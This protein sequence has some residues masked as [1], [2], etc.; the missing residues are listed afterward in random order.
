MLQSDERPRLVI[1]QP[2]PPNMIAKSV[3]FLV[4]YPLSRS[5][6]PGIR[7][8]SSH[9][10]LSSQVPS[11]WL[12]LSSNELTVHSKAVEGIK[13][14][15]W[16]AMLEGLISKPLLV[17]TE[18]IRLGKLNGKAYMDWSTFLASATARLRVTPR[19]PLGESQD[20]AM[21]R[22]LSALHVLRCLLGPCIESLIIWDRYTWAMEAIRKADS[23]M[24]VGL[25]NLFDQMKGSGRN[26]AI[27]LKAR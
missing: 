25:V 9:L 19:R 15:A 21:E 2:P 24:E 4:D 14:V 16:R 6:A 3:Y 11:T 7:L 26:I 20:E 17:T 23:G 22:R 18:K 13:K 10:Q 27:V 1:I 5:C 8:T 12:Q